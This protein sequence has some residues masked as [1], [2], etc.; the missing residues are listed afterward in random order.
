MGYG[1]APNSSH[2]TGKTK[3]KRK[4]LKTYKPKRVHKN[5]YSKCNELFKKGDE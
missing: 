4:H 5:K 2:F 3:G 1:I